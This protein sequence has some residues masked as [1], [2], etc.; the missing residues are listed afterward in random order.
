MDQRGYKCYNPETKRV[1]ISRHVYF[2][3]TCFPFAQVFDTGSVAA[4][5]HVPCL[6]DILPLP[7]VH[8]PRANNHRQPRAP[9]V[10]VTPH[11]EPP[12]TA[13]A[14][15]TPDTPM[16]SQPP[17]TPSASKSAPTA[18]ATPS[19]SP[20]PVPQHP[21]ITRGRDD[22]RMPN[23]KYAHIATTSSPPSPP[24]SVRAALRDPA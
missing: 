6:A 8:R 24:T 16:G 10:T 9:H 13:L 7:L 1:I 3:E 4:P 19:A 22:I 5:R 2:D 23:P 21:M 17:E 18:S 14:V 15:P 12:P 20:D 11:V